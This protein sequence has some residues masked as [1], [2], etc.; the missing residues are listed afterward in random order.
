VAVIPTV[1]FGIISMFLYL[2]KHPAPKL[3]AA[4]SGLLM[5]GFAIQALSL[6]LYYDLEV[7]QAKAGY[8][9]TFPPALRVMNL[10]SV[11]KG[12]PTLWGLDCD[13]DSVKTMQK[14]P[15]QFTAFQL[16]R[17]IPNSPAGGILIAIWCAAMIGF[18]S[19]I[20]IW[21]ARI[22]GNSRKGAGQSA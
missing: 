13:N 18:L 22:A 16:A 19:V 14:L 9:V 15:L 20:G 12:D 1:L 6:P 8:P 3:R 10:I 7:D 4:F 11:V 2:A 17:K 21:F 5:A